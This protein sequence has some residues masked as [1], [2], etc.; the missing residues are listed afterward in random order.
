MFYLQ[1]P[2]YRSWKYTLEE[3]DVKK[4]RFKA[5]NLSHFNNNTRNSRD[6]D[7]RFIITYL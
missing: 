7:K 3:Q 6:F 2:D 4:A 1:K 5:R